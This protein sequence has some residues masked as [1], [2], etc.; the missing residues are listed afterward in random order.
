M[1]KSCWTC[2][3]WLIGGYCF[4]NGANEPHEKTKHDYVCDEWVEEN[5]E[6]S[7]TALITK[8]AEEEGVD[9]EKRNK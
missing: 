5:A 7:I 9:Y 3:H 1:G 8:H 2:G 4:K 6:G